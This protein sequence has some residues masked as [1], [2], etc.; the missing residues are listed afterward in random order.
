MT[1]FVLLN[2]M[3]STKPSGLMGQGMP[4]LAPPLAQS[5]WVLGP[6]ERLIAIVLSGLEGPITVNGNR[7]EPPQILRDMPQ[8]AVLTD[9]QIADV[10]SY[11]RRE[12]DHSAA[13]V[14]TNRVAAVRKRLSERTLPFTQE[15]LLRLP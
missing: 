12:W 14:S 3:V 9:E 5:E 8:I 13:G 10:L 11:T 4:A 7:Y 1:P 6:E 15:E 2:R